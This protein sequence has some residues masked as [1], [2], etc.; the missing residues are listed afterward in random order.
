MHS[1]DVRRLHREHMLRPGLAYCWQWTDE[2]GKPMS[3]IGIRTH[4]RGLIFS[5]AI[6]GEP[7]KQRVDLRTTPCNYGG[8]R[9][10]FE[11]PACRQRVAIL[12]FRGGLRAADASGSPT[13]AN[14]MA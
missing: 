3:T 2:A 9:V 6:G 11:C 4:N 7:V 1:I 12:L 5:Y 10:W 8:S 13:R 14:P